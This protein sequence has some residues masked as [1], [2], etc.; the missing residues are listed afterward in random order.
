MVVSTPSRS[1]LIA[2]GDF[3][4]GNTGF[5]TDYT[6]TLTNSGAGQYG[7]GID[8]DL[9]A[10][11]FDSFG[12]HTTGTD[13]MMFVNGATIADQVVWTQ[14][15]TVTPNTLYDFSGWVASLLDSS[16]PAV[17]QLFVN[18]TQIGGDITA[19][20]TGSVW[21]QFSTQWN[22]GSNSSASLAIYDSNLAFSPND[23]ALDDLSLTAVPVPA[24]AWL[25]ASGI[26]GLTGIVR[27]RKEALP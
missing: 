14:T 13:N 5:N 4:A 10:S 2:N 26:A 6:Y 8:P 9:W 7:I 3:S 11:V 23:F 21:E 25:F 24:A 20:T 19:S 16:N 18:G 22:S 12:D 15:V 1:S 17:L 27:R